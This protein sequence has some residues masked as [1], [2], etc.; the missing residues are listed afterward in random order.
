M[1]FPKK[2]R[3]A[4]VVRGLGMKARK[5][6]ALL[7]QKAMDCFDATADMWIVVADESLVDLDA[8][9]Q[10]KAFSSKEEAIRVARAMSNGN[11]DHRVLRVT[12]QTLVVATE[13]TL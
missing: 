6:D 7:E 4:D 12:E 13:N 2:Y 1:M 8:S 9:V 5:L 11:V 10:V 3:G